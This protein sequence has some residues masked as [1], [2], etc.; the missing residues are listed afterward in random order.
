MADATML[1]KV[2]KALG[3]EGTYQD[4]TLSEYI[5]MV[6]DY[7]KGA[8]VKEKNIKAGIVAR[9]VSDVWNYNSG[10]ASF[11]KA[12]TDLATQFSYKD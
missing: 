5:D 6:V 7:L 10:S 4:D 12:F 8:G 2:K 3:I 1:G 9:G 11:S